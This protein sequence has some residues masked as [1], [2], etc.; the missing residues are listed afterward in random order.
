MICQ[1]LDEIRSKS[2]GT[3][4]KLQIKFVEDRRGHDYRYAIDNSKATKDLGFLVAKKFS[5]RLLETVGFY[6]TKYN[7]ND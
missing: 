7:S 4:Y 5:D 2:S 6:L 3:S 1:I